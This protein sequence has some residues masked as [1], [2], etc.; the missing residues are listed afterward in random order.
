MESSPI[1][2]LFLFLFQPLTWTGA[3]SAGV[4]DGERG[5]WGEEGGAS[6]LALLILRVP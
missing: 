1:S 3:L 6:P 4:T 5:G 2:Y